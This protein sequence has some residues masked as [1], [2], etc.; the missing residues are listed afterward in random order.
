MTT[1]N[2]MKLEK[3]LRSFP[4][5]EPFS[6]SG[7]KTSP[8]DNELQCHLSQLNSDHGLSDA[9]MKA[10]FEH[11]ERLWK[12]QFAAFAQISHGAGSCVK[13]FFGVSLET[14]I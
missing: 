12:F 3:R 7:L 11:T 10:C 9:G 2:R 4:G 1:L 14:A 6:L 5:T 13:E 8:A